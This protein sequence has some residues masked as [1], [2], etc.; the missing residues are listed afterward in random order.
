MPN[1]TT[2]TSIPRGDLMGS[3]ME[4]PSQQNYLALQIYP[5]FPVPS[6]TGAFGT[7]P[8]EAMVTLP[9]NLGREAKGGYT[10]SDWT[11]EEQ[12]YA[13]KE[14][15]HEEVADDGEAKIYANYFNY[16]QVMSARGFGIVKLKQ[17]V[18]LKTLLHNTTTFPLSGNTGL[19]TSV[20]WVTAATADPIGD[21]SAGIAGVRARCGLKADAMQISFNTWRALWE[22]DA[23]RQSMKYVTAMTVP[24]PTNVDAANT[25]AKTLGLS[26]ILIADAFYNSAAKGATPVVADVWSDSYAFLFVSAKTNDIGE[27]CLGR[28]MSYAEDGGVLTV[29]QYRDEK[30]RSDI[31]RVRQVVQEKTLYTAC[32]YLLKID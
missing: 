31:Y 32:G 23:V 4:A 12:T 14:Y 26:K 7:I 1:K 15:G 18:R 17:E 11:F 5:A 10:R 27:P 8:L 25:L 6:K 29:E 3:L 9:S 19:D 24:D 22:C 13:C 20:T 16:E 30:V 21:V 2:S 28:T